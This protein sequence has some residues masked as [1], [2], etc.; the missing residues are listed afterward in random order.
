MQ[1][2]GSS[3]HAH[4]GTL[5]LVLEHGIGAAL[6]RFTAASLAVVA[7][8]WENRRRQPPVMVLRLATSAVDTFVVVDGAF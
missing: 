4:Q 8:P 7:V 3:H 2:P 6:A 5:N 1:V